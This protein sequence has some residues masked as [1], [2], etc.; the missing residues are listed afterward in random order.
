MSWFS[1]DMR[2]PDC[3]LVWDTLVKRGTENEAT[4][5]CVMCGGAGRRTVSA[6]NGTRVSNPMGVDK[7]GAYTELKQV[8][9]LKAERANLPHDRRQEINKE[10]STRQA[11][12]DR[13]SIKQS[14]KPLPTEKK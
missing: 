1:I 5:P 11:A 4:E 7:G 8:A 9:R 10:I 13:G 6:P 12:A 3:D 2:C 14:N